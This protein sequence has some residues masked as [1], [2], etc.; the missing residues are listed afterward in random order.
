VLGLGLHSLL[1]CAEDSITLPR[2]PREG[3]GD[4]R[5]SHNESVEDDASHAKKAEAAL[6]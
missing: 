4:N 1:R 5:S 6:S 2:F 3:E